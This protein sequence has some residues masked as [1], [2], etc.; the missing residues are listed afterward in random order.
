MKKKYLVWDWNGTLLNDVE[1][2]MESINRLLKQE[3]LPILES[4]EAYQRV[5]QFPIIRYYE[6][7]GFDFSKRPYEELAESYMKYYQPRSLACP[8][9]EGVLE[10]LEHCQRLGYT[11]VL[12]SASKKEYL[13]DQLKQY[14]IRQYFKDVIGLD[15]YHAFSKAELARSYVERERKQIDSITFFGDS[16]HDFE[17]A[18]HAQADCVLIA[19][20]HEHKEKL[21]HTGCRV[22]DNIQELALL[23][24]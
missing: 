24:L 21:L 5:F 12:I 22:I 16:V 8:L 14:P 9:H 17:V 13:E 20:G 15:N 18:K 10:T 1:L 19:N 2:C 6:R 11:Q 4:K 3:Q 7:V 23:N